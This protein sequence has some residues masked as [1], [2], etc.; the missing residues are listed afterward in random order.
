M[1]RKNSKGKPLL[2]KA[3][4][5]FFIGVFALFMVFILFNRSV[6]AFKQ[7]SFFRIKEV[8]RSPSLQFINSDRLARLEGQNIFSIDL[9]RIQAYLQ[10]EYP[11]AERLRIYRQFPDKIFVM[12][13]KREPFAFMNAGSRDVLIDR[14]GVVL[15]TD[16]E[17]AHLKLPYIQGVRL[18]RATAPGRPV[19]EEEVGAALDILKSMEEHEV[20]AEYPVSS[21][22]VSNLSHIDCKLANDLNIIVDR[23]KTRQKLDKLGVILAQGQL[24]IKSVEY[25]DLRF[26]E[27]VLGKTNS[28]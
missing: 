22:D 3:V 14:E 5:L 7:S 9:K 23:D 15:S 28:K 6:Q 19:T 26:K 24:D 12:A 10:S 18:A 4:K 27:P 25:I 11:Q 17:S 21:I 13:K 8:V 20:L 2:T 16:E 1:A